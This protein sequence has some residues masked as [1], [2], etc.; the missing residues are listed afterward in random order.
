MSADT[1][2][3]DALAMLLGTRVARQAR[4]TIAGQLFH[5]VAAAKEQHMRYNNQMIDMT[6]RAAV[7]QYF[8][9]VSAASLAM[10]DILIEVDEQHPPG[11]LKVP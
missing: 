4:L 7:V 2:H 3:E 9:E 6:D 11:T 8:K 5:G 1:D 10:A